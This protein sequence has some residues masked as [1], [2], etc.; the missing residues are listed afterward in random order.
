[1]EAQTF[2][3]T[4]ELNFCFES[5]T[6]LPR[7][8]LHNGPVYSDMLWS[9]NFISNAQPTKCQ[10]TDVLHN[11]IAKLI[12]HQ[13]EGLCDDLVDQSLLLGAD[14]M[15]NATLQYAAA[16]AMASHSQGIQSNGLE[17]KVR[18]RWAK[19]V[20]ALLNYVVAIEV[21]DEAY[22]VRGQ[23]VDDCI[24]LL[25]ALDGLNHLLQSSSSMLVLGNVDHVRGSVV[26]EN[27]A[28]LGSAMLQ[29]L[30]A[31]IV[32]ERILHKLDNMVLDFIKDDGKVLLAVLV[33]L[34]LKEAASVLVF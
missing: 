1:M 28:L 16:M 8:V 20:Q 12:L 19:M 26:D 13:V 3:T 10:L 14:R 2:S 4:L 5:S 22:N 11:I 33:N 21:L 23:C 17:D 30:L 25:R 9:T 29:E 24:G 6:T 18:V 7:K 32:S 27:G 31:Q 15:V 34:L